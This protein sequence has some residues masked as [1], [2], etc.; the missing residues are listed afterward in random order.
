MAAVPGE[1]SF[2]GV[3]IH[4]IKISDIV[5]CKARAFFYPVRNQVL[6][7]I[8]PAMHCAFYLDPKSMLLGNH[9]V[10]TPYD[11]F[12]ECEAPE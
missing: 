7:L 2:L 1:N 3:R 11:M 4:V 9:I 12:A 5:V 6:L 10:M 8:Y